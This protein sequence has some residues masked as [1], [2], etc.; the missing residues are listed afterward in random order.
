MFKPF[1]VLIQYIFILFVLCG[2]QKSK[3]LIYALAVWHMFESERLLQQ[4][5]VRTK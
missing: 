5:S 3:A 2:F 1:F 4:H